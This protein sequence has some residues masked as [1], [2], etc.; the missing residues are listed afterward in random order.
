MSLLLV[1]ALS[2]A[3]AQDAPPADPNAVPEELPIL[4]MPRIDVYVEAPY[5]PEAQAAGV[6][7]TVRLLVE[8]DETGAVMNATIDAPVGQGFDEAAL[9]AV[10]QMRFTPATTAEGPVPVAFEF[11][12]GFVLKVAEPPPDQPPAEVAPAPVN[13]D[14]IVHEMG[15]RRLLESITL[16]VDGVTAPDGTPYTAVTDATGHF[17]IRGVPVGDYVLRVLSPAHVTLEQ[18]IEVV[19]GEAT[20]A[21]LWIRALE[22]RDNEAV[23]IYKKE[24][25]EVT[26]RTITIDEV[27]KVPGTF[28]DPVKVVQTLPGAARS[29]FG[30]GL[31]VIRG[32]N[33]EDSG[34]YVDGVRI[35]LIYHLTGT[36]SVLSP[37]LIESVDYL[38]GGFGTQYGRSM[39]GVVDIKTKSKFTDDKI[40]WG[41][42][43]LDSQIYYEGTVDKK[44]N[45]GLALGAR[46]SYIDVF[47]PYVIKSG[48]S[49]KPRYWDW[50]AKWVPN[51]GENKHLSA[52]VYG[53]NDILRIATP[54]GQAQGTDQDTQGDIFIEYATERAVVNWEHKLSEKFT[55][56]V[57]PSF[58]IDYGRTDLG[59]QLTLDSWNYLVELRAEGD[60][61]P[62][63]SVE[64]VPGVDLIGGLWK[65]KFTSPFGIDDLDPLDERESVALEGHGDAWGPD[66][67]LKAT[68]RPL[69]DLER[70]MIQPGVRTDLVRLTYKGS[71][72][73]GAD[74]PPYTIGAVD[75]RLLTRFK[76]TKTLTLKGSTGLYH[77]PPQPQ[78][79]VGVGTTAPETRFERSFATS[80]GIEHQVTPGLQWELEGFYKDLSELIVFDESWSGRGDNPFIN[81]GTGKAYGAEFILRH[82]KTGPF[83]G[84]VSYTYSRALRKDCETCDEYRFEFDQPH[85]FSAQG[86]YD[87]PMDFSVSA[88][89]QYVSGNPDTGY[90]A[91]V[92]DVD[93]DAYNLFRASGYDDE[94]LP[95]YFQTSIRLDRLWT[96]RLWQVST[97]VDLM[98]AVR[99]VNPEFT[100]YNYDGS[101]KAYVRGMPFI[102]NIGVEAKFY[103]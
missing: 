87:L 58:G 14:G 85:I 61:K 38:P 9:A 24:E 4:E 82:A 81:G 18:S 20:T 86:G 39:G 30:T 23:G 45:H 2:R 79:S 55:Y 69:K 59:G 103:P 40:I 90:N 31:L 49:I 65:F 21:S 76:A 74:A 53:F 43:I 42:D 80:V 72:T 98:N 57:T 26:R 94:R 64:I 97:Y 1:L 25:Q 99:G 6:E 70:L 19:A 100:V 17:E 15:T 71:I 51:L 48:L 22:Y 37:D 73:G 96:F 41:T 32:S 46:R 29:P 56:R 68:L 66:F 3:L 67:Y 93:G 84:W 75:P 8:I 7:A 44:G 52:F 54:P 27:R 83:F 34:V 16:V 88:Q 60:W 63:P 35:P 11:D 62:A 102:P 33:P 95:S 101:E 50:Q 28:G 78:E 92:F 36:T 77:Q 10:K 91:G 12:Y 13:L 5:P 89:V 47:L